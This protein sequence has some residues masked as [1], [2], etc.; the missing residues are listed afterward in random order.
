MVWCADVVV[1]VV[2]CGDVVVV[3]CG[4]CVVW[5][6][7]GVVVVWC[8]VV[9]VTVVTLWCF[10]QNKTKQTTTTQVLES[11]GNGDDSSVQFNYLV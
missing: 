8:G 9:V 2:W 4:D 5:W 11:G 7:C 1:C 3:W 6:L 10:Q